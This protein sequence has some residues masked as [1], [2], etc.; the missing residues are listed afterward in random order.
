MASVERKKVRGPEGR[1][2]AL[3]SSPCPFPGVARPHNS[4]RNEGMGA[5]IKESS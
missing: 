2:Q 1:L 4:E 3:V 5:S